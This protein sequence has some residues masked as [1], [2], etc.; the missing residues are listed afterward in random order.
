MLIS[1]MG[2][3]GI[4]NNTHMQQVQQTIFLEED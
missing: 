3:L 4:K 2:G 1:R